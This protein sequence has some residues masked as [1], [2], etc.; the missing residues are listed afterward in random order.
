[1]KRAK[2]VNA[3][4]RGLL[5]SGAVALGV[6]GVLLG[7]GPAGTSS[8]PRAS[9]YIG[10]DKCKNCHSSEETGDQSRS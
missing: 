9:K 5:L 2:K 4:L 8:A 7:N 10:A 1:M 3:G 6:A